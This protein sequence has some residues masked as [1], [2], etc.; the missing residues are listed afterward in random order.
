MFYVIIVKSPFQ[1]IVTILIVVALEIE[2]Q[3]NVIPRPHATPHI[4]TSLYARHVDSP[5]QY[6]QIYQQCE[7]SQHDDIF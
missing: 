6:D 4:N 2:I 5:R 3:L 1:N 7:I